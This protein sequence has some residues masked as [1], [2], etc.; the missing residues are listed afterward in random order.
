MA[1]VTCMQDEIWWTSQCVNLRDRFLQ[2]ADDILVRILVKS[3][4]AVADLHKAEITA[5]EWSR[6]AEQFRREH[7]AAHRPKYSRARPGH[8]FKE[9]AAIDAIGIVVM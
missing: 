5:G 8:A 4:V 6:R 2:R 7:A 3:D 9:P 1:Q